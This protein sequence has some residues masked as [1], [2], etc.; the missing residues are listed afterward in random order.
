VL[1]AK[2]PD[3]PPTLLRA[4]TEELKHMVAAFLKTDGAGQS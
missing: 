4:I 1:A 2:G 3:R